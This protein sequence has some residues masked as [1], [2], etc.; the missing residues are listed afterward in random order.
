MSIMIIIEASQ[1]TRKFD[2]RSFKLSNVKYFT[3]T[4]TSVSTSEQNKLA[5][6]Y[7][8]QYM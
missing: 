7:I 8:V 6:E 1:A 2:K 3:A 4:N 5:F